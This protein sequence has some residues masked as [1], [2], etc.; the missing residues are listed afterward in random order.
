[1]WHLVGVNT[2]LSMISVNT[3]WQ[4]YCHLV[5]RLGLIGLLFVV[6]E[7]GEVLADDLNGLKDG[8]VKITSTLDGRSRV[9]SGVIVKTDGKVA[10]I[11]TV[12]HVIEGDPAPQ[13]SFHGKPNRKFPGEIIGLDSRNPK[14]LAVLMVQAPALPTGVQPLLFDQAI[15]SHAGEDVTLIGFP[16]LP[17]VPWAVTRGV[18]TGQVGQDLILSGKASEGNSGGPVI[19]DDRVIGVVTEVT[20]GFVYAVP[21]VIAKVALRGWGISLEKKAGMPRVEAPMA[22][23]PADIA[24]ESSTRTIESEKETTLSFPPSN[25][26]AIEDDRGTIDGKDVSTMALIPAGQFMMGTRPDDVCEWDSIVKVEFC[27]QARNADYAPE[28]EVALDAFYLDI[29]EVT[30][31]RFTKFIEETGYSSTVATKGRQMAVVETSTFIF[32]TSWEVET[33]EEADWQRPLGKSQDPTD[34]LP[35]HPVVQV[36]WF[37]ANAYCK[38]AGKRLPRE[39]EWEYAAR[40]G[41]TTKHWWGEQI[42]DEQ[43]GNLP[44]AVYQAAFKKETEFESFD[45][46]EARLALVGTSKANPWGLYDIA[47]NVWEWTNDWY[48]PRYYQESSQRNPPGP[49]AGDEKVKRGGSWYAYQELKI[50]AHQAPEDSDDQTGF[51]CARD[52][53][54]S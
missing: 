17:P 9:G 14:G 30:K 27:V 44:D 19:Q 41:T 49:A 1:M 29:H 4:R 26:Q 16:R 54:K 51:R 37:D 6:P 32:G 25:E 20:D 43:V 7:T 22:E 42:P 10:Y 11:V 48:D 23:S 47:G 8:V 39:A 12:S 31:E 53:E 2:L 52:H 24:T 35:N 21:V 18:V 33:V 36:S 28:H 45:D 46:G 38:W 40:A 5:V 13:I 15:G 3:V 50:R 34:A